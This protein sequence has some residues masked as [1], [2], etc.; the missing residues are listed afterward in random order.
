MTDAETVLT[1]HI[2]RDQL[3]AEL[4]ALRPAF[5]REGVVHMAL[6]GSRARQDNRPDSDVDLTIDVNPERRFS[7][8]EVARIVRAV[9][10][11]VGFRTD[12]LMRRSLT[13][14]L[15]EEASRDQISV[16]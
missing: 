3:L 16:F 12:V 11:R 8:V 13:P 4:R 2:T 10:E 14:R 7:L 15:L 9:E 6:V 5:E 1:R